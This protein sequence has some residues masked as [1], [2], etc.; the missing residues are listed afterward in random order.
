MS[1]DV[2]TSITIRRP[3]T[4]VASDAATPNN[5]QVVRQHQKRRMED[6]A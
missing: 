1:V 2:V 6:R 5:A 3:R 4:E